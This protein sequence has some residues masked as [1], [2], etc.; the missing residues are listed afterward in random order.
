M[1]FKGFYKT[2]T[3]YGL[4]HQI[5]KEAARILSKDDS[6]KEN[7]GRS[8]ADREIIKTAWVRIN[9]KQKGVVEKNG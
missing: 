9:T 2:F 7:L 1:S 6:T 3:D 8:E 4:D 5:A